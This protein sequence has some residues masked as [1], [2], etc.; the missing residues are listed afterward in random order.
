MGLDIFS[1]YSNSES[2]ENRRLFILGIKMKELSRKRSLSKE[3]KISKIKSTY[4]EHIYF[5]GFEKSPNE[6]YDNYCLTLKENEKKD[7][8]DSNNN[9]TSSFSN[10][11][12]ESKNRN[13]FNK[14]EIEFNEYEDKNQNKELFKEKRIIK[15]NK[16]T[17]KNNSI[18]IFDWDDTLFFTTH[19][20]PNKNPSLFNESKIDKKIKKSI[21][22]YVKEILNKAL[23][24]GTVLI[25]TNSSEGWVEYC[26]FSYYR[27]LIPL[28][29][30]L[31]II[32]A[33]TLYEKEYPGEPLK[34]KIKAFIDL[35]EKFNFEKCLLINIICIGDDNYEKIA[36]KKL[37][38]NF[39][40][41]LI[42][43]IKLREE[44]KLI[45]L[46]KQLIL[47]NEQLLRVYSY[48][49]SLTIYVNKKKNLKNNM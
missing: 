34:W 35:K 20:N 40:N 18:F 44:P 10:S 38:E 17:I 1:N 16:K 48:Q 25:I 11:S 27:N 9:S 41:C 12:F 8:K 36:A 23:N 32:S 13:L 21:E 19:L 47:I 39:E 33:R 30:K 42:K 6:K 37:A 43:T 2:I 4:L 7:I 49:K 31:N 24:N 28:L 45:E 3:S 26:I 46:I 14:K 5:S 22:Y 15:L 29:N